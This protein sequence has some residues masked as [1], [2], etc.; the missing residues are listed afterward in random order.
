MKVSNQTKQMMSFFTKN[1]HI[2]IVKQSKRTD[3][4]LTELYSDIC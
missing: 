2:N 1:N 3:G 4:I